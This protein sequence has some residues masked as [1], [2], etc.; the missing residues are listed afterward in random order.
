MTKLAAFAATLAVLLVAGFGV[1]KALDPS[2]PRSAE[3]AP[4][5]AMKAE[6]GHGAMGAD[7]IRG[8]AVAEHGLRLV[9]A[10]PDFTRDRSQTLRFRIAD[11]RGAS[12]RDFDVEHTKRMHLIVVRRDLSGFQHLHPRMTEDGEWT[13]PLRLDAA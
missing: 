9:V 5:S 4:M 8:L 10:N 3:A 12:V 13:A 1:G 2:P 6:A 11:K 7:P